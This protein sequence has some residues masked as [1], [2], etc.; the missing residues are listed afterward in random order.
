LWEI[1]DGFEIES[2][3]DAAWTE[4]PVFSVIWSRAQFYIIGFANS[5]WLGNLH[6]IWTVNL[7]S[8]DKVRSGNRLIGIDGMSH[9]SA[10]SGSLFSNALLISSHQN[11]TRKS[12]NLTDCLIIPSCEFFNYRQSNRILVANPIVANNLGT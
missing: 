5:V 6:S 4:H 10:D 8:C 3:L 11:P 7:A 2:F 9:F 12:I 1:L